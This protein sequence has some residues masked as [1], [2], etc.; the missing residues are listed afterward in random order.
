MPYQLWLANAARDV[1][2][3]VYESS[4]WQTRGS[5]SFDPRG[6]VAHHTATPSYWTSRQLT[7]LL[8]GGHGSLSGPLA[9]YQLDRDG[10]VIV[11]AGGRA[12]HAGRG[13]WKGLTGNRSV[14]GI[15]AANLGNGEPWP[16][17]QVEAYDRLAAAVLDF[18]GQPAG[19]LCAHRE[20]APTRKVDPTG[21]YMP[22]MRSRVD[23]LLNPPVEDVMTPQQEAK[24]D[25]AL[26]LLEGQQD[27][28]RRV[29][30]SIRA[31]ARWLHIPTS[32]NGKTDG[33]EVIT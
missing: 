28:N 15:E 30:I 11:I 3:N 16:A 7:S 25:R 9:N 13:G 10:D 12:N 4:G 26:E 5:S 18:L 2:L 33:T 14:I 32:V 19:M 1:G 20:W 29:R 22:A 27:V 6:V 17:A 31:I 23:R 21:I 24:L 8:V